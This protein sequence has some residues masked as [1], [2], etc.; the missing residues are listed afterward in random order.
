MPSGVWVMALLIRLAT[1]CRSRT[2]SPEHQ[3][4]P[5]RPTVRSIGTPRRDHPGVV[6]GVG[7]E[8]EQV[9]GSALQRPLLVQAGQQQHVLHQHAHPGGLALDPLHDPV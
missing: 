4:G 8:G 6:H 1:T 2:S 3:E 5:A 7:G 9:D